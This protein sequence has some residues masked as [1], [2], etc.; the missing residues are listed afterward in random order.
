MTRR[1][2]WLAGAALGAW[3]ALAAPPALAE[4]T[5][6]AI[7]A[8][9]KTFPFVSESFLPFVEGANAAGK[10]EFRLDYIGGP[11]IS[12]AAAQPEGFKAGL[13]DV[14]FTAM[15]YHRGI[16]P[17]VDA[18]SGNT[19]APWIARANGGLAAFNEAVS[20]KINGTVL[21]WNAGVSFN[22][23]LRKEPKMGADG[24]VDLSGFKMRSVPT[25]DAFLKAL[26]ATTVTI[27]LPEIHSALQRGI[28]D[29]F[30]FPELWTRRFGYAKFIKYRIYPNFMQLDTVIAINND[31]SWKPKIAKE[32]EILNGE[33]GQKEVHLDAAAGEKYRAL[34]NKLV[35]DRLAGLGTPL[36]KQLGRLYHG[37]E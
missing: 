35:Q 15:S 20:A 6:K 22:L 33:F 26:G 19:T 27:H 12:K 24:L 23:Y 31:A 1:N 13:F 5:L 8:W 11:E 28:V 10:G 37:R 9:P 30:A 16:I 34:A 25:Y 29:G 21:V 18:L 3:A 2:T 36:A 4:V 7:S 32:R 17:E 14:M